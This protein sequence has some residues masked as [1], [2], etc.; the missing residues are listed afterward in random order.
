MAFPVY[1][2]RPGERRYDF[3]KCR[4]T[5]D[6]M[7]INQL[8][9]RARGGDEE[10]EKALFHYLVVRFRL[11]AKRRIGVEDSEDIA[12]EA[13]LTVLEKYKNETFTSGFEAWTYGVLKM[14]IG[15]YIQGTLHKRK[16]SVPV[17]DSHPKLQTESGEPAHDLKIALI[18]CLR[19][20]TKQ[21]PLY[22]RVLNFV[23]QGLFL[24][25]AGSM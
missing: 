23:H 2:D 15:N 4:G 14:K 19:K 18:L 10:A 21:N 25:L 8:L 5:K 6:A 9:T 7:D 13:C 1:L 16:H 20:I 22:A 11:L 3:K 12:Q 24:N 17:A